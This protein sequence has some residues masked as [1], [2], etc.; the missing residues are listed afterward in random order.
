MSVSILTDPPPKNAIDIYVD[1][2]TCTSVTADSIEAQ[3]YTSTSTLA[4]NATDALELGRTTPM[5]RLAGS[6]AMSYQVRTITTLPD[7]DSTITAAM[8]LGG[9]IVQSPS[10]NRTNVFS[11]GPEFVAALTAGTDAPIIGDTIRCVFHN[12][13][14]ATAINTVASGLTLVGVSLSVLTASSVS[15]YIRVTSGTTCQIWKEG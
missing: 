12:T 8:V 6:S 5:L 2:I 10:I 9:C 7:A 1:D 3:N 11:T 14:A 13:G 15:Y 4:L